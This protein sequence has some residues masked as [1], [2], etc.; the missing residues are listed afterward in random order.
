MYWRLADTV[1]ACVAC[2]QVIVLDVARD[3]YFA[4]PPASNGA[5]LTWLTSSDAGAPPVACQAVL[6]GLGLG[7]MGEDELR[8]IACPVAMPVPLDARELA[9]PALGAA[10]LFGVGRA[11]LSA[12]R[13]V[14]SKPL[15]AVLSRRLKRHR[16]SGHANE[17]V[18]ERRLAEFRAARPLIPIPRV[19]LHDCLALLD[20]LGKAGV[21][22]E[23]VLGVTAYPF[24]AHSWVQAGGRVLDDHPE[25]ASRFQPIL[26][27]A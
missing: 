15:A 6:A 24:A 16:C 21:S 27:F 23:L 4:V 18:A 12:W 13:D 2:D 25:S 26:H 5:F 17:D 19:C 10:A 9:A 8:P 14:R 1:T 3:R 22:P 11:V 7:G 20:W